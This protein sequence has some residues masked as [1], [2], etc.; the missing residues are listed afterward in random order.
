MI[1]R[2][3]EFEMSSW[4]TCQFTVTFSEILLLQLKKHNSLMTDKW[5]Q[6]VNVVDRDED[7][8]EEQ[9]GEGDKI[10]SSSDSVIVSSPPEGYFSRLVIC[11]LPY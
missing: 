1:I 3:Q 7:S 11:V 10:K 2:E 9:L 8:T 4:E 5:Q 6:S